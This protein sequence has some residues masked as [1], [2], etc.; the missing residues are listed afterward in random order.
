MPDWSITSLSHYSG[1]LIQQGA[2][3]RRPFPVGLSLDDALIAG[4]GQPVQSTV[5]GNGVVKEAEAL[6]YGA[7]AGDD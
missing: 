7:V 5:A 2:V 4:I 3:R 1:H 6:F